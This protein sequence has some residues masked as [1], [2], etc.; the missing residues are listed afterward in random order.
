MRTRDARAMTARRDRVA[1]AGAATGIGALLAAVSHT[2][3]GGTPP[4][5]GVVLA[6]T[7]LAWP[8]AVLLAGPRMRLL[9]V[10]AGALVSQAALH[11]L[12]ALSESGTAP[13]IGGHV[14]G[15]LTLGPAGSL[16]L[17][18]AGMLTAHAIAA[19]AAFV[20]LG[21]GGRA[22]RAITAGIRTAA[23]RA[24]TLPRPAGTGVRLAAPR[25]RIRVPRAPWTRSV[26]RRGPP[27]L[28]TV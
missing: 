6:A 23:R 15:T 7:L 11:T 13:A 18:S 10:A 25:A 5:P 27:S 24:R 3:G 19:L 12:F 26:R 14:H 4:A 8:V 1:R 22:L 28:L 20:L 16:A 21:F 17:P 9:G 2:Y